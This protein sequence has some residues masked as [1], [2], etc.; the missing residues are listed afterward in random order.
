MA[1]MVHLELN[2]LNPVVMVVDQ[3]VLVV[4]VNQTFLELDNTPVSL[5]PGD[6]VEI[7]VHQ[8]VNNAVVKLKAHA[9]Q[10][11]MAL[12]EKLDPMV[13]MAFL[14]FQ[15]KMDKML[16]IFI[17]NLHLVLSTALQVL[18]DQLVQL[19]D[20]VSVVCV[21]L[22]VHLDSLEMMASLVPLESK[23]PLAHRELMENPEKLAKKEMMLKNQSPV[24]DLVATPELKEMKAHKGTKDQ[25][26]PLANQ[27]K[28]DLQE[29]LASKAQLAQMVSK[30]VKDPL[31]QS[32]KMLNIVHAQT[33]TVVAVDLMEDVEDLV[34][35]AVLAPV[36]T[37]TTEATAVTLVLVIVVFVF[38]R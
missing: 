36:T 29:P 5:E 26:V 31:V 8:M 10:V 1:D 6:Q 20:P 11:L 3:V 2:L 33:A 16:K 38:K 7:M 4:L 21:D 14:V 34:A 37:A 9:L 30:E 13:L 22:K 28:L 24:K 32:A 27:E 23:D 25:Q 19:E 35:M 15:E 12:L 18:L 17:K